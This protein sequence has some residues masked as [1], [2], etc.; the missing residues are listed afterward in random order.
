VKPQPL[1]LQELSG[2]LSAPGR[3]AALANHETPAALKRALHRCCLPPGPSAPNSPARNAPEGGVAIGR[4]EGSP[5][6]PPAALCRARYRLDGGSNGHRLRSRD[7]AARNGTG[8][9]LPILACCVVAER[10]LRGLENEAQARASNCARGDA[11]MAPKSS[12]YSATLQAPPALEP[13][14][15]VPRWHD[16]RHSR[17]GGQLPSTA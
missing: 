14:R 2:A 8:D 15:N 16:E 10:S 11:L 6:T 12:H 7:R 4:Y 3:R 17:L 1:R 9:L 13:V 5:G